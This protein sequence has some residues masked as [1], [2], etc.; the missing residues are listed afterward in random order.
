MKV[1]V[2]GSVCGKLHLLPLSIFD[3]I[4][5][6][7]VHY[8]SLSRPR[9]ATVSR[10]VIRRG[11]NDAKVPYTLLMV[12]FGCCGGLNYSATGVQRGNQIH[13]PG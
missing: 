10:V 7:H 4:P 1:W 2:A 12:I 13:I 8:V 5:T 6:P 3:R 9:M 11:V